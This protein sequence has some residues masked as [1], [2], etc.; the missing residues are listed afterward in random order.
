[1]TRPLTNRPLTTVSDHIDHAEALL[2]QGR[3]DCAVKAI[4][5]LAHQHIS[6]AQAVHRTVDKT[7]AALSTHGGS[8]NAP[9]P[10]A[11]S[12]IRLREKINP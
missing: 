3:V 2:N 12:L 5:A 10:Q 4:D 1:M 9:H 7:I 8:F 11:L 6:D